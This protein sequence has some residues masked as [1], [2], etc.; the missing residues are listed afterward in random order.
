MNNVEYRQVN[1]QEIGQRLDNYL[2]RILKGVPKTYIYKIIRAGEVRINKKRAKPDTRLQ[3]TDQI[4][5]QPMRR[6][7][8]QI[9][10]SPSPDTIHLL[11]Q[12]ILYEDESLLVLNKPSGFAVHGGSG[13]RLGVIEALRAIRYDLTYLELVHR[14]D[15]DTSGCLLLAKKRSMLRAIHVLL[16]SR[17]VKKTYWALLKNPWHGDIT[18]WV[19]APLLK[20]H[21]ASG[22]WFVR[23][24]TA[25]KASQTQFKLIENFA[26]G[27]WVAVIPHTGRT[28]QI[29]VHSL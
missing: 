28:H 4:R 18:Q 13:V 19:N 17:Q 10:A 5:I 21:S 22:E 15:R 23:V 2:I 16:E 6:A 20:T 12:N 14:L 9:T 3:D 8:T 25:G 29:R 1:A 7:I 24:N 27:C 26:N 11:K